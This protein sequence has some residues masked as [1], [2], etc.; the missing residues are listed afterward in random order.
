MKAK[1]IGVAL[2]FLLA[3]LAAAGSAQ[4]RYLCEEPPS[5]RD[6][7]ACEAARQ[8]PGELR[9]F[10]Q[11]MEGV[12]HLLFADYVNESTVLAWNTKDAVKRLQR[13]ASKEVTASAMPIDRR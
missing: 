2:S 11:R 12:E 6:A 3:A 5:S 1:S 7:R 9:R 8:G 4:A 13:Q 10:I